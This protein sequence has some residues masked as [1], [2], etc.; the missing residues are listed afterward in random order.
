MIID[1]TYGAIAQLQNYFTT[2]IAVNN[3]SIAPSIIIVGCLTMTIS[4]I[5]PMVAVASV[6]PSAVIGSSAPRISISGRCEN[7]T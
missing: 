4:S 6:A 3:S 2:T 5:A 1:W 7:D